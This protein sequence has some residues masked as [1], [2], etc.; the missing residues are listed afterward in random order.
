SFERRLARG[1]REDVLVGLFIHDGGLLLLTF[2]R[3]HQLARQVVFGGQDTRSFPRALLDFGWITPEE[4]RGIDYL[5]ANHGVVLAQVMA[6]H[7]VSPACRGRWLAEYRKEVA[8]RIAPRT[9]S[10]FHLFQYV[11]KAH[12]GDGLDVASLAEPGAE[13]GMRQ[14]GLV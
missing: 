5:A 2:Q 12:D 13:Q 11:F 3:R 9:L 6:F 14:L 10:L 7:A 4:A 1:H 8:F